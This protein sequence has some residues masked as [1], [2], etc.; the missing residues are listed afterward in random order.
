[1]AFYLYS[2]PMTAATLAGARSVMLHAGRTYELPEDHPYVRA[3]VGRGRLE[4]AKSQP[5]EEAPPRSRRSRRVT[6]FP[7]KQPDQENTPTEMTP[8]D[9]AEEKRS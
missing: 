5:V 6:G 8:G 9:P 2:G 3:L 1:M 7:S 4:P